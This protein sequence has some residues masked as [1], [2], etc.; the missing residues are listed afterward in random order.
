MAVGR[1]AIL[2]NDEGV[3]AVI[4]NSTEVQNNFG[5]YLMLA[6]KE[7]I[8]ITRN[9]LVIA[10]LSAIEDAGAERGVGA[11]V[12]GEEAARYPYGGRKATFEEFRELT[13]GNEDRYEYIDGEVYAL[14]SPKTAHQ[15][16]L[17]ELL[18]VFH[19]WLQGR[20]CKPMVAPY[21]ITL[22]RDAG[23]PNV[24]QPDVMVI[25]DLEEKLGEDDCYKGV[26]VLV[27]EILSEWTR[28]KDL[29]K[30]LDLYMSCGVGEYW[31]V[32]PLNG[33]VAVYLFEDRNISKSITYR[34]GDCAQSY[35]FDGLSVELGRIFA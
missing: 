8:I 26:P 14:D 25:C 12:T 24:V 30:K 35:T 33:E 17:V 19:S 18:V 10:R 6:A 28:N 16:A 21:D 3:R 32:N 1:L 20:E 2:A 15:V 34:K 22:S 4:V 27:V 29:V 31:I 5:R 7:D 13:R 9:G 23:D 11:V